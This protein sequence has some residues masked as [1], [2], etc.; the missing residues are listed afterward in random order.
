MLPHLHSMAEKQYRCR[1]CSAP[2]RYE[3]GTRAFRCPYCGAD[4]AFEGA[5]GR[6]EEESYSDTLAEAVT[7]EPTLERLTVKCSSCGAESSFPD[8]VVAD[9]CPF[10]G[11][12]LVATAVSTRTI[13]PRAVLPFKIAAERARDA[14]R[15]WVGSLWFAPSALKRDASAGRVD[16]VYLPYWTF[17]AK[18]VSRYTGERG[19]DYKETETYTEMEGGRSV[20]RTRE[21]TKT[22]WSPVSGQVARDFDDVLVAGTRSLPEATLDA[23]APWDL[24]ELAPTSEEYLAGYRVESYSVPLRD[25]HEAARGKIVRVIVDDVRSDIGGDSQRIGSLD[26]EHSDET[27]KHVLLP[28]WIST[29]RFG[30]RTYRFLVNARTGEVQGE[31]PWSW[32][33][34]TLVVLGIIAAVG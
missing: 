30:K 2:V 32:I 26:T 8:N 1:R 25:A 12:P 3:P 17:D 15:N 28:L 14:F 10:C 5:G 6:V 29:Y 11:A 22:S 13:R 4:Q 20:T 33:K 19:T 24:A 21:V 34:I 9:R 18:T 31:R 16:G 7:A 27:F 23:L